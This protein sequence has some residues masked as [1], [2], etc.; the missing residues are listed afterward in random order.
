MSSEDLA[1]VLR[2]LKRRGAGIVVESKCVL[3]GQHRAKAWKQAERATTFFSE[4]LRNGHDFNVAGAV[5]GF[6]PGFED[7]YTL[8]DFA[9]PGNEIFLT[10][11]DPGVMERM[12]SASKR[13]GRTAHAIY[14]NIEPR[15]QDFVYLTFDL[16]LQSGH[17][18]EVFFRT[19]T[20]NW[21]CTL[22][23]HVP[24]SIR[25][26][27]AR[28]R[29]QGLTAGVEMY[30]QG[31]FN[32]AHRDVMRQLP[33]RRKADAFTN[34]EYGNNGVAYE[35]DFVA[36]VPPEAPSRI[37]KRMQ[38]IQAGAEAQWPAYSHEAKRFARKSRT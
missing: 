13:H 11:F 22:G 1:Q 21:Y 33:R 14:P 28:R 5:A 23:V 15:I 32:V 2:H 9:E 35:T 17:E 31:L 24:R 7:E 4:T 25:L 30:V 26:I 18:P 34:V 12:L 29:W 36:A 37:L 38:E 10:S 6:P 8:P 20:K 19:S 16:A 27:S 3:Y